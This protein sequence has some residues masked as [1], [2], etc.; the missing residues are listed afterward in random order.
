MKKT[1][2]RFYKEIFVKSASLSNKPE[3]KILHEKSFKD[4]D[5]LQ[6]AN[7]CK[8]TP[9]MVTKEDV[10]RISKVLN[11]SAKNFIKTYVL[12]DINGEL[13]F[14]TVPCVFLK[15]N[16]ECSIY[17]VRPKACRAYPHIDDPGFYKRPHLNAKNVDVCPAVQKA[18]DILQK[19][20]ETYPAP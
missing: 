11:M 5:C 17:E 9:A 18:A 8:T 20:T 6:C 7:C 19:L 1:K 4:V 13:S 2:E 3:P 16:N 15:D 12:E 10:N 14:K